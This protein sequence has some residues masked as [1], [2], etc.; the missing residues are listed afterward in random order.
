MKQLKSLK[1]F[2][3]EVNSLT[4]SEMKNLSGGLLKRWVDPTCVSGC[5]DEMHMAQNGTYDSW[6][7]WV[8]D[9]PAWREYR[10][11]EDISCVTNQGLWPSY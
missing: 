1:Q 8:A 3:S 2:E 10:C 5:S 11:F 9:G 6:G 7:C 4:S